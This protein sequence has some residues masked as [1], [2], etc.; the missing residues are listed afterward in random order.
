MCQLFEEGNA[1]FKLSLLNKDIKLSLYN[2]YHTCRVE[3]D[4]NRILQLLYNFVIYAF[5]YIEVDEI[6]M[7]FTF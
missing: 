6:H 3:L 5:K 7:G 1:N 2:P 4:R